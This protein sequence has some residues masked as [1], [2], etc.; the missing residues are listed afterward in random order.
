MGAKEV[1][2]EGIGVKTVGSEGIGV[3]DV[4]G[5]GVGIKSVDNGGAE[6]ENVGAER[7]ESGV[8]RDKVAGAVS[9]RGHWKGGRIEKMPR[10]ISFLCCLIEI[11]KNCLDNFP[12][13]RWRL[14][15]FM[16]EWT[17]LILVLSPGSSVA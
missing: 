5:E 9:S 1:E 17:S 15:S 7:V 14:K 8:I 16:A 11:L 4:E 6:V 12:M 3:E 13:K 10:R 2:A